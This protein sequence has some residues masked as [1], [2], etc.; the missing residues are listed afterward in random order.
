M[1]IASVTITN[2]RGYQRQ[3]TIDFNNLTVFV[4]WN[5][6]G[7]S[8]ILEALD[9]FF[10]DGKGIIKYD[11]S[12]LNIESETNEFSV[13]VTFTELPEKIILDSAYETNLEDE[14]MLNENHQLEIVKTFNGIKC[15]GIYINALHPTHS[16]CDNL[17]VKKHQE[18]KS[19]AD[20]IGIKCE[21]AT[22]NSNLRKAI[23]QYYRDDLQLKCVR[24]DMAAGEDVKK[25]W[26]K[27]VTFLPQYSLFQSDRQNSD[28]DKEI[29]DP[30]KMA[31]NL[32]FQDPE[33]QSVLSD[34][35]SKVEA[36]LIEV[37]T[38]TLE[39]LKEMDPCM[40]EGLRPVVPSASSLKWADVFKNVSICG[41]ENIPINKR[42]SGVRRLILLN[43]FRAEAE[44]RV[45]AGDSTGIIY[46]IEEP[47]TSQHFANQK[48]LADALIKLSTAPNTQVILTTHSGIFVK[49]LRAEDLRLVS[50]NDSNE[51]CVRT[52]EKG[53]LPYSSMNEI[54]YIAFGEVTEEYHDE[55]YGHIESKKWLCDYEKGKPTRPYIRQYRDGNSCEM[56]HTL[57][58]YIRDVHHHPENKHNEKYTDHELAQSISEMRDFITSREKL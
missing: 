13:A 47:E 16:Q 27:L 28:G 24:I 7:K 57:T 35:A 3:T 52:I 23:W 12:D 33:I 19:I 30:L 1:K 51:K 2:F 49:K 41:D 58:H 20:A 42:G 53:V 9:L 34:V 25:I 21:N 15:T 11:K 39:K 32:F 43:F 56:V 6:I 46:A 45:L 5:D 10:N 36:R 18:L 54:N 50:K 8:T 44:R 37:S 17:L 40:A 48:I 22:A 55:L 31:V 26:A 14:Y 38:R 4:G 29:Q